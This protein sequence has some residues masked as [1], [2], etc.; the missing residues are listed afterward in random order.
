[1]SPLKD[2][3]HNF[4][5]ALR[6]F[7]QNSDIP[8]TGLLDAK[9]VTEM[10]KPRCGVPDFDEDGSSINSGKDVME[11]KWLKDYRELVLKSAGLEFRPPS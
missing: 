11:V 10:H 1:M 6:V 7:Q 2:G 4:K 8:D 9:T 3:N 5:D